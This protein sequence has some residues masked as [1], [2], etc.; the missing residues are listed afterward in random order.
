MHQFFFNPPGLDNRDASAII[1]SLLCGLVLSL[2]AAYPGYVKKSLTFRGG[3]AALLVGSGI[4]LTTGL[5]GFIPLILFFSSSSVLSKL[6]K[7]R[8]ALL[9]KKHGEGS[10][11]T[12]RQVLA[13]GGPALFS[14]LLYGFTGAPVYLI[15][16]AAV[17]SAANADT[18]ASEGGV[19]FRSPT[20]LITTLKPV[21]PGE[22]G[23]ISVPGTLL[24][25]GGAMFI[26][27]ACCLILPYE[28]S[29]ISRGLI[30]LFTS[31][32]GFAGSLIDSLL[33]ATLQGI[34]HYKGEYTEKRFAGNGRENRKIRGFH[35]VTNSM[36][37]F[38]SGL[39]VLGISLLTVF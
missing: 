38:L 7:K 34:Y 39:S 29:G 13:N 3:L 23:G 6:G 26:S 22:S 4:F 35:I 15:T 17:L 30:F 16:T 31:F 9:L 20:R 8:K 12:A 37:N 28:S 18:W 5:G 19:L 27:L 36:V 14:S 10:R 32:C 2:L 33:G 21:E 24:S 25:L 1:L 11:R